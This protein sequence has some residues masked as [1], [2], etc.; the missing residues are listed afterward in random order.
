[1]GKWYITNAQTI[2]FDQSTAASNYYEINAKNEQI[3]EN[4]SP[5]VAKCLGCAKNLNQLPSIKHERCNWNIVESG[6][7]HHNRNS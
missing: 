3:R 2:L 4:N 1:M 7:K 6:V 5:L